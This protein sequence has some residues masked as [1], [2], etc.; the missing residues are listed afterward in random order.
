MDRVEALEARDADV[1]VVVALLSTEVPGV[2]ATDAE[3]AMALIVVLGEEKSC[4]RG[5]SQLLQRRLICRGGG[6][7]SIPAAS[8]AS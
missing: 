5:Y 1:V 8:I 4:A 3:G 6:V 7:G 2:G